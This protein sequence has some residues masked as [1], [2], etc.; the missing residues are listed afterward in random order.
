M[1]RDMDLVREILLAI[2]KDEKD[3]LAWVELELP[4]RSRK[5][6]AYHV[7]LMNQAG[8]VAA[9]DVSTMGDDGFDWRPKSLTWQ[10]H[11]FLEAA[12]ND[13]IWRKAVGKM[14]EVT[15]GVSLDVLKD[16]LI[17]YGKQALGLSA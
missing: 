5:E 4:N 12:R 10:G 14:V 8:L 6:V 15:G 3:P 11:E 7:M 17:A 16:L 13:T 1:R 9:R 2:E